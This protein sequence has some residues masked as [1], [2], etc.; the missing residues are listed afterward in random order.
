MAK[1]KKIHEGN[2]LH[3]DFIFMT[4]PVFLMA[5]FFYGPRTLLLG[6]VAVSTALLAD[7]VSSVLRGRPHDS[8]EISSISIALVLVLMMPANVRFIIVVVAVLIAVLV[9]KEAFGGYGSY[10]FNPAAVGFCVAAVSWP[11]E[12]LSYPAPSGW[13]SRPFPSFERLLSMWSFEGVELV[14][15]PSLTLRNGGLPNIDLWNLLLGNYAGPMGV[16]CSL[17]ILACAV[18]LLL[19]KRMELWA[20]L[21]FLGTVAVIAFIFPRYTEISF[22]T[23]PEDIWVRLQVVKFELF[24]GAIIFAAVFLASEVGTMPKNWTSQIL[25]GIF[26]GLATM[27]FRYFGIYELGVCFGFLLVNA[28]SGYFDRAVDHLQARRKEKRMEVAPK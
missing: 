19:R 3:R 6:L 2:A 24:S 21:F 23:W 12:I 5:F 22:A 4:L 11:Q 7:R 17:V 8:S 27:L 13:L 9:G 18:Y 15:G 1:K 16:G 14:Q 26:L 28:F 20:P 10:P 25:Y